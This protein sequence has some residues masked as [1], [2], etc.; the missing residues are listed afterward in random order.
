MGKVYPIRPGTAFVFSPHQEVSG[1]SITQHRFRNFACR[2]MPAKGG[3]EALKSKVGKL[4]GVQTSDLAQIKELCRAAV[5]STH[6][7]D[8]LA[9]QQT[10][11][12]CFQILAKVWRHAHTPAPL[13]PESAMLRLME[14]LR[15]QPSQRMSLEEMAAETRLSVAQFSRRFLALSGE[16]PMN[17]AIHQRIR[18]AK[19][20]LH[21]S[22]LRI[23]EIADALGYSDIYFFSRQFKRETGMSPSEF[24]QSPTIEINGQFEIPHDS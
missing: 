1:R 10:A 3:G 20:Y 13:N 5:Q 19:H 21:G 14:R 2:F 11:G 24:R 4:M 16:S 7:K 15:E 17:F 22:S 23:S 18:H 8:A 9:M 6:Y 12:L